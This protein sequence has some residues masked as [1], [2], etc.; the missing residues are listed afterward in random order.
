MFYQKEA[1]RAGAILSSDSGIKMDN[2]RMM[3]YREPSFMFVMIEQNSG[4]AT[5][6]VSYKTTES[7]G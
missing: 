5:V 3:T 1:T 2:M 7:C 6:N 4:L